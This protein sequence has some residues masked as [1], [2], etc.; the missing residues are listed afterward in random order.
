MVEEKVSPPNESG[1][2]HDGGA[3]TE[4]ES[5]KTGKEKTP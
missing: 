5:D 4:I 3:Y 2:S 1:I